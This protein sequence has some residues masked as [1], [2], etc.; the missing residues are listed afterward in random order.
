MEHLR[1]YSQ[2][3][4]L[5]V[6]IFGILK[7]QYIKNSKAK[8]FLFSIWYAVFTELLGK[9]FYSIFGSQNFIVFNVY[10]LVQIT[11]YLWWFRLLLKTPHRKKIV[12]YFI[13][14]FL[15]FN[16][17]EVV[18]IH[19]AFQENTT[20]SFALGVIFLVTTICYFF[21][22]IFNSEAV[23]RIRSSAYFW[24][25]LGVI[26]FFATFLP[27]FMATQ[28]F[29]QGDIVP[30]SLVTFILN[31]IMYVCFAIGF[32]KAKLSANEHPIVS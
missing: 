15:M 24:F 20:F 1:E 23:L 25:S 27:F 31:L 26:L 19:N 6:A 22:E 12:K 21:I 5:A 16:V 18:F 32:F 11:F 8:Y 28:F 29:L 9:Y 14:I 7:Y 2:Y 13:I 17:I 4:G 3:L 30:L 10:T